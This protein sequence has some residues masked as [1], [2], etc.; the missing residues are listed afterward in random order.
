LEKQREGRLV[1]R[2]EKPPMVQSGWTVKEG[3]WEV[4]LTGRWRPDCKALEVRLGTSISITDN[5]F[6]S[7]A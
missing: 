7:C 4:R 1:L 6:L 3:S 5:V 2:G